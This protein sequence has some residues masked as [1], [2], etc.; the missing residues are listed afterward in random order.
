M[1]GALT[2]GRG[3]YTLGY[4]PDSMG[5]DGRFRRIKVALRNPG[6]R[7]VTKSGYY[8]PEVE[9]QDAPQTMQVF[10]MTE[11]GKSTLPF[12]GLQLRVAHIDRSPDT[13]TVEFTIVA[14]GGNF[15]WR[16]ESQDASLV[17]LTVGGLGLSRQGKKLSSSF[18][19]VNMMARS[20]DPVV[21][22]QTTASF[23][24]SLAIPS[25]TDR[26]RLVVSARNNGRLGCVD[27]SRADINAA[28]ASAITSTPGQ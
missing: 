17:E 21:L 9:E 15:P 24:L 23:K 8:A 3:S 6:L 13:K 12:N 7:V 10:Q 4:R 19:N 18:R 2:L 16:S 5:M 27:V 11:A 14:E 22:Q 26:V 25:D 20:R 1:R 28:P